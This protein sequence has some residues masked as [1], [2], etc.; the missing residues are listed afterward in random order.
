ME[1]VEI[2]PMNGA[3]TGRLSERAGR[4]RCR[5]AA[6]ES[7]FFGTVDDFTALADQ[8]HSLGGLLIASVYPISLGILKSPGE[9]G[10]DIAVGDGQSL[11]NPLSF[12][13]PSFGFIAAK[14][15]LSATCRGALSARPSTAT[16]SAAMC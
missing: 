9:M 7:Q 3:L 14:K 6:A 10:V 12:G 11:G 5:G 1:I 16:A 4:N 15:L 13:G 2:A 8:V